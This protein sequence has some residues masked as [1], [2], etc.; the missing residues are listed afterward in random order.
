M[1]I[2][3]RSPNFLVVYIRILDQREKLHHKT[4]SLV[5]PIACPKGY[6]MPNVLL[7]FNFSFDKF[8]EVINLIYFDN[9]N[10]SGSCNFSVLKI[11]GKLPARSRPSLML[12]VVPSKVFFFIGGPKRRFFCVEHK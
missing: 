3:N 7:I 8:Y 5:S 11:S 4:K 9:V 12:Q 2:I 10:C 6:K 1:R